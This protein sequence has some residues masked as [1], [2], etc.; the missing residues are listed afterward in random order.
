MNT[1]IKQV[2]A[3]R[4]AMPNHKLTVERIVNVNYIV[5]KPIYGLAG[6]VEIMDM[7]KAGA[8]YYPIIDLFVTKI[9]G[10]NL[11]LYK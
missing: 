5:A 6:A 8:N 11:K 10:N 2:R 1:F 3:L 4:D 7:Q 9:K